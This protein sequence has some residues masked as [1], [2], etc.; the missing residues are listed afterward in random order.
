MPAPVR[1]DLPETTRTAVPARTAVLPR[2]PRALWNER[3][4][5]K[6]RPTPEVPDGQCQS[7]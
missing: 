5:R 2:D 1:V 7:P 3:A 4:D 6:V